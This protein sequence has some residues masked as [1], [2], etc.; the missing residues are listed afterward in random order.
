MKRILREPL[1]Q[2]LLLGLLLFAANGLF[3]WRPSSGP[4]RIVVTQGR[5][6]SL[7]TAFSLTWQRRPTAA[8][9]DGLIRDYV[10][11]E[12]AVREAI[13]L[14]LD[15]DDVII[16]RRL[17]QKLEFASEDAA[18]R[19]EPSEAELRAWLAA[20]PGDF[21]VDPTFTFSHVYLSP[22]KRG[23]TLARDAAQ[24]LARLR[25]MGPRADAASEGDPFLLGHR[26][27][28]LPARD[29]KSQFG[30]A[31]AAR[32]VTLPIGRWEGPIESGYGMHLV[33]LHQRAD[34]RTPALGEVREAVRREWSNAQRVAAIERLYQ[35]LLAR[36]AVT[37]EPP[38]P[39]AGM[40]SAGASMRPAAA[41][42]GRLE[43]PAQAPR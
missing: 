4:R 33:L 1:L 34:A 23:T 37:I 35:G 43:R 24:I 21:G 30:E 7:A 31:F 10:R 17:R 39:G 19:A 25:R 18:S 41:D 9:L 32:L 28:A 14:G 40:D 36:Y 8:E 26:F 42:T 5:I 3:A 6:E 20:H 27:E 2:F 22:E 15:K 16:R 29:V 11:E 38:R 13:A 12:A